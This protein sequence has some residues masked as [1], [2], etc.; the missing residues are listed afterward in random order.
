ML[1]EEDSKRLAEEKT[2]LET[3]VSDMRLSYRVP[4]KR[5]KRLDELLYEKDLKA[6]SDVGTLI[7]KNHLKDVTSY[8]HVVTFCS[9]NDLLL[10]AL[11]FAEAHLRDFGRTRFALTSMAKALE[12]TGDFA[13][14]WGLHEESR[15]VESPDQNLILL[16]GRL[17]KWDYIERFAEAPRLEVAVQRLQPLAATSR[18]HAAAPPPPSLPIYIV[19][20]PEDKYRRMRAERSLALHGLSAQFRQ[21][22]KPTEIPE[23]ERG[24]F[25]VQMN[26]A[27]DG[28]FGNQ[29]SQYQIWKEIAAGEQDFALILEDDAQLL[30][31][32]NAVLQDVPLPEGWD[33]I[34]ANARLDLS[35]FENRQAGE[36]FML[37]VEE[38]LGR[39]SYIS[40]NQGGFGNDCYLLSRAGARKLTS[41]VESEGF[42]R[43]GTDWYLQTHCI[44]RYSTDH[45]NPES[46]VAKGISA[47]H[48]LSYHNPLLLNGYVLCP[49]ITLAQSI[50]IHRGLRI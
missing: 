35:R 12:A 27:T 11:Y 20:L 40:P 5:I 39:F 24:I 42:H 4:F 16:A 9:N 28:S 7:I 38:V 32:P 26:P 17:G 22:Y 8:A 23:A 25:R 21:G 34:F 49:T 18:R 50:G 36:F 10:A 2:A 19:N 48:K 1:S 43:V 41:I 3:T 30:V 37:S 13:G 44:P 31:N 47:R 29:Y 33:I 6:S 15:R 14:A 46:T 45:F